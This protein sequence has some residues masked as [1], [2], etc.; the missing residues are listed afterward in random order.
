MMVN[1]II[2]V[3]GGYKI[4]GNSSSS[5]SRRWIVQIFYLPNDVTA[6]E[7]ILYPGILKLVKR[8]QVV[9]TPIPKEYRKMRRKLLLV[10]PW[11][12]K[13]MMSERVLIFD[14]NTVLCANS[15]FQISDFYGFD[16][17]GTPWLSVKGKG[18]EGYLSMR[19]RTTML[20]VL[21]DIYDQKIKS[22]KLGKA[23]IP[24]AGTYVPAFFS[25]HVCVC[26]YVCLHDC[27]V[28]VYVYIHVCVC[29]CVC[30][31]VCV[32]VFV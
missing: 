22:L 17:I 12:W 5:S 6:M 32:C 2:S 14:G 10:Q 9:L 24:F 16:Y 18:G 19:N 25:I 15:L 23:I 8:G 29:L 7:G 20:A 11:I 31:C 30:V 1:Q 28:C 13:A 3:I 4:N 27:V 21:Q 26:V